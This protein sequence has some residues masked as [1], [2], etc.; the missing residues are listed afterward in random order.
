VR[1][2]DVELPEYDGES[3]YLED[4]LKRV[5]EGR[6]YLSTDMMREYLENLNTEGDIVKTIYI[7]RTFKNPIVDSVVTI[8]MWLLLVGGML[9]IISVSG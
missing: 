1:H 7:T 4:N 9:L 3:L 6:Y 2:Y 8:G 5:R